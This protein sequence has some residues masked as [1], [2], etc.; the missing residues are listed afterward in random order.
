MTITK[1]T[2]TYRIE[3]TLQN[4]FVRG[5]LTI[6]AQGRKN[7]NLSLQEVAEDTSS[8]LVR[9]DYYEAATDNTN[10]GIYVNGDANFLLAFN[11]YFANN[12]NTIL[13]TTNEQ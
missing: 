6:D 12:L 11:V 10:A 2:D 9:G 4:K 8:V 3:D 5:Y 7:V 1:T 13:A